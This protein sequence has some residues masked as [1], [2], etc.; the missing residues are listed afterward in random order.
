MR[1]EDAYAVLGLRPGA[2]RAEIDQAYRRLIKRYHPDFAGGDVSRAAELNSAY[3]MLRARTREV[4]RPS[5]AAAP[6]ASASAM[7]RQIYAQPRSRW[8]GLVVGAAAVAALVL[9]A[10]SPA[11]T[12]TDL[13]WPQFSSGSASAAPESRTVRSARSTFSLDEPLAKELIDSSVG[14]A[15]RLHDAKDPGLAAKVSLDCLSRLSADPSV[16]LF[17]SCAAYDEAIAILAVGDPAFESGPFNPTAVTAR[18]VGAARLLSADYFE[19]ESRLQQIRSRVHM[20][21]LPQIPDAGR[22]AE[23]RMSAPVPA[24]P[25]IEVPV[26][27][28]PVQPRAQ[29]RRTV[30]RTPSAAQQ[31][32]I[33]RAAPQQRRPPPARRTA[34]PATA[35]GKGPAWQQPIKPAWQRS[36]PPAKD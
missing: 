8:R 36:L 11:L 29:P 21:L 3:A 7:P 26:M 19:A 32:P 13:S 12:G 27:A 30:S 4:P 1:G 28:L 35:A 9:L 31:Q 24:P 20:V 22:S 33:R 25:I 10:R 16:P 15:L 17:D 14:D 5:P 18:Q 6:S 2:E 23:R 34:P